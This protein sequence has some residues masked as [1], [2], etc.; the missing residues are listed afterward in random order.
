MGKWM[1]YWILIFAVAGFSLAVYSQTPPEPMMAEAQNG[2][3]EGRGPCD[4]PDNPGQ[5]SPPPPPPGLCLPIN[6]Y[7]LPLLLAGVALGSFYLIRFDKEEED[8]DKEEKLKS[9]VQ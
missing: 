8:F 2:P 1:N 3:R 5:G 9:S 4:R 7:L 6:D